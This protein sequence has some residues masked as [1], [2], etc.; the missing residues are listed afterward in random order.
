MSRGDWVSPSPAACSSQSPITSH[1]HMPSQASQPF[2]A[3]LLRHQPLFSP[4]TPQTVTPQSYG[5][6]TYYIQYST[7]FL[8]TSNDH[9]FLTSLL[10]LLVLTLSLH[11]GSLTPTLFLAFRHNRPLLSIFA[12]SQRPIDRSQRI[13]QAP[14]P[15]PTPSS[16]KHPTKQVFGI[17]WQKGAKEAL[18]KLGHCYF[19]LIHSTKERSGFNNGQ[20]SRPS[21]TRRNALEAH[22]PS[23][24]ST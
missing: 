14:R 20:I 24:P 12:Q 1:A 22:E 17:V 5:T 15:H 4:F 11:D 18:S 9:C 21:Y 13:A 3:P 8:S 7:A 16:E 6:V 23:S 10:Q 2:A 19:H